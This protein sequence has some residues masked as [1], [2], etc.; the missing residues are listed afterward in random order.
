MA[1]KGQWQKKGCIIKP[2]K[3][4]PWWQSHAM[5]PTAVEF[6]SGIIRIYM[7]GWDAGGISRIGY[8]DVSADDPFDIRHISKTPVLDIGR[9]GTFD[10]NGVFPGH[11]VMLEGAVHLYY[12]G[13]QLGHKVR[14]YN[15][16]GLATSKDGKDFLR[17]SQAPILDRA[18]EGLSVRAGQS[19]FCEDGIFHSCYSAGSKWEEVGGKQRPCYDVFYQRSDNSRCFGSHGTCIVAC[20]KTKEHGLGRPQLLKWDGAYLVCYTR[21]MCDMRYHMGCAVS[22]DL[23]HWQREDQ[24]LAIGHGAP[25]SFD[26]DMVY[27]PSLLQ[28]RAG[29][30][31]LFYSGNDFGKEGLGVAQLQW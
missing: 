18:D 27:F 19:V 20:D 31:Y 30:V 25:G 2:E 3:I 16:G 23:K 17:V 26:S 7:G 21:R 13:F 28:T 5:A 22:N 24:W 6:P 9:P 10:E 15:F 4:A 12:T 1:L 8:I 11:A 29:K 14:H